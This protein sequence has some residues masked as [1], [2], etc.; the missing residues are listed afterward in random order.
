MGVHPPVHGGVHCAPVVYAQAVTLCVQ[1]F[2]NSRFAGDFAYLARTVTASRRKIMVFL[3]VVLMAVMVFGTLMEVIEG[4]ENG[5]T[6][7]P[8][9]IYWGIT[10]MTTVG[11]GDITPKIDLGRLVASVM[12]LM[13]WAPGVFIADSA[14]TNFTLMKRTTQTRA[15]RLLLPR[16]C[17]VCHTICAHHHRPACQPVR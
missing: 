1:F 15:A 14:A 12:M 9:A 7:I 3:S 5:F 16:A 4:P 17:A 13:G 2:R 8:V 6:R 10:T 11:F